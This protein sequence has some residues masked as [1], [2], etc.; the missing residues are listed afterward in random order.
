M[1]YTK[2]NEYV[3]L[4]EK[5]KAGQLE[6]YYDNIEFLT[7]LL[8]SY[9]EELN[10]MNISKQSDVYVDRIDNSLI[11][12][13]LTKV[14]YKITEKYFELDLKNAIEIV[15]K[16]E[17]GPDTISRYGDGK[18]R[19]AFGYNYDYLSTIV[20][21]LMHSTN[22]KSGTKNLTPNILTEFISIYYELYSKDVLPKLG[23]DKKNISYLKKFETDKKMI[24]SNFN[25]LIPILLK[26]KYG[27]VSEENLKKLHEEKHYYDDISDYEL[28]MS[29]SNLVKLAECYSDTYYSK[30]DNKKELGVI[31]SISDLFD[32]IN[33]G[34]G[35]CLA[36]YAKMNLSKWDVNDIN[37]EI[38]NN[39]KIDLF[40][41]LD[42]YNIR[43]NQDF[44]DSS[45]SSVNDY[46]NLHKSSI[47]NV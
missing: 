22:T 43:F 14:S 15:N 18:L 7:D 45:I 13:L 38:I 46:Y 8:F 19:L 40:E 5:I 42:R 34:L 6:F 27:S 23:I 31:H 35:S 30:N 44:I 29:S 3:D 41:L 39:P 12:E 25:F 9:K 37:N 21:E 2:I 33:H 47:L 24:D 32:T 36:F 4:W 28:E 17:D 26:K 10:K 16:K 1:D 20:H 11:E